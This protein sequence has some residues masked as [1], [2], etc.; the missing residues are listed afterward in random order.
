MT[1]TPPYPPLSILEPI[2]GYVTK[3]N[4]SFF[5]STFIF[6]LYQQTK[7]IVK[8]ISNRTHLLSIS[9]KWIFSILTE[10]N[11]S[12]YFKVILL[13][14]AGVIIEQTPPLV[15]LKVIQSFKKRAVSVSLKRL[16]DMFN[17]HT[18]LSHQDT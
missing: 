3:T 17:S 2:W 5:L 4:F 7:W 1:W 6:S 8:N 16:S 11:K 10:C 18:P 12:E 13:T 15:F 14:V 9:Q